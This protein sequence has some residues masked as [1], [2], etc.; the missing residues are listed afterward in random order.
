MMWVLHCMMWG[1]LINKCRLVQLWRCLCHAAPHNI[2]YHIAMSIIDLQTTALN[3]CDILRGRNRNRLMT[4]SPWMPMTVSP[5]L[6]ALSTFLLLA[7]TNTLTT[8]QGK[9]ESRE[10]KEE[11]HAGKESFS[12]L[13]GGRGW[14][15]MNRDR[16]RA[17]NVISQKLNT[18]VTY[19]N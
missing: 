2:S 15:I 6:F 16:G 14:V 9:A 1:S 5:I 3:G 19:N 12:L 11:G 10:K 13:G 7:L 4:C 8:V 17:V 18:E